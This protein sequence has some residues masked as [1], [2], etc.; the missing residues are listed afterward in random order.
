MVE[1]PFRNRYAIVGVGITKMGKV[2]EYSARTLQ[3]EAVRLAIQDAGLRREDIDGAINGRSAGGSEPGDGGWTDA[4]PRILGL[5][6]NFYWTMGRGIEYST[7]QQAYH[8]MVRERV[9]IPR[10]EKMRDA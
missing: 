8:G 7:P 5:P 2:P 9:S 4:F 1:Q 10:S 3:A 6:V